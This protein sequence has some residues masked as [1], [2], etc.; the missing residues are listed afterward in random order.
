MVSQSDNDPA[1]NRRLS[2]NNSLG[3]G[4][5]INGE[6]SSKLKLFKSENMPIRSNDQIKLNGESD[7]IEL[8]GYCYVKTK[9]GYFK[10][11]WAVLDGLELYLFR[12]KNQA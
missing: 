10:W 2:A 11:H 12:R 6:D 3:D 7:Y 5:N 4:D 8:E 9:M 1:Q